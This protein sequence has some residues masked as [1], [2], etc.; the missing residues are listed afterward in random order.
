MTKKSLIIDTKVHIPMEKGVTETI[1]QKRV[2]G[3]ELIFQIGMITKG[4]KVPE[5]KTTDGTVVGGTVIVQSQISQTVIK[6]AIDRS[7][8]KTVVP[9]ETIDI[10]RGVS[11][12]IA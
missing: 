4:Q 12:V 2:V 6:R 1:H 10:G 5:G 11:E 9:K 8:V 7:Q 3:V